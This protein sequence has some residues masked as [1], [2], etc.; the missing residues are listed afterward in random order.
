M[1]SNLILKTLYTRVAKVNVTES[2]QLI[3]I[4]TYENFL[5]DK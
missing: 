2:I 4:N 1:Q 5:F 3:S